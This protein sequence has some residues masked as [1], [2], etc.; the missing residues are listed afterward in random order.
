MQIDRQYPHLHSALKT[1]KS[2]THIARPERI[3]QN[4]IQKRFKIRAV[5]H[6]I[7]SASIP[8]IG[9]AENLGRYGRVARVIT[10]LI[11]SLMGFRSCPRGS[12]I[13]FIAGTRERIR[14]CL[15]GYF[16]IR[17]NSPDPAKGGS[18]ILRGFVRTPLSSPKEPSE[19][20]Q[21]PRSRTGH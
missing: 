14:L 1:R 21:E 2:M 8:F 15:A 11:L 9:H 10:S 20:H 7:L 3:C 17:G 19:V 6:S 12:A 18:N 13:L 4:G 5:G 16:D